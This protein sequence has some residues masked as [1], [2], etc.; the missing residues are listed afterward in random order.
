MRHAPSTIYISFLSHPPICF[1]LPVL[2]V[3]SKK[4]TLPCAHYL[5][6]HKRSFLPGQYAILYSPKTEP[7]LKNSERG[8]LKAF[9]CIILKIGMSQRTGMLYGSPG[10]L[11][12]I[13][14]GSLCMQLQKM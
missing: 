8:S 2:M 12:R 10:H 11:F 6:I 14:S 13:H 9:H 1:A 7:S 4:L 3:I 5:D